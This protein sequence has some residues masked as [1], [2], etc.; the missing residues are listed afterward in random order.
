MDR[1]LSLLLFALVAVF[2]ANSV[3]SAQK[4]SPEA[5]GK[6]IY[7]EG[8][9][10][11]GQA[12]TAT[13]ASG[14]RVAGR[15]AACATCHRN[16][17]LGAAEGENIIRPLTVPGFFAGQDNK[18]RYARRPT[19]Q[20]QELHYTD[21]AF[22]HALSAGVATDG[23]VLN[24]L[25]PRYVLAPADV[26]AL[27]A[28][29][30]SVARQASPG[31]TGNDIHFATIIAPDA[32]PRVRDATLQV[33]HAMVDARNAGTRG[34]KH[35]L[36]AGIDHMHVT[37]RNWSLHVW[38]LSGGVETWAAQLDRLYRE[39]PVFAVVSGAGHRWQPVHDFCESNE[40]PCLF[41]NLD[42][43]GRAAPSGYNLYLTRG[44]LLEADVMA[45]HL[46]TLGWKGPVWQIRRD[47]YLAEAGARAFESAWQAPG[48]EPVQE[49]VLRGADRLQSALAQ[50]RAGGPAAV[51]L[52]LEGKDLEQQVP[53][54]LTADSPL[55]ASG[56]L[57]GD[58]W[59]KLA[60]PIAQQLLIAWPFTLPAPEGRRFDPVQSWLVTRGITSGDHRTQA[61]TY[62][63]VRI[64]SD[65]VAH[66]GNNYSRDYL[67]ERLEHS[68][69]K[70]LTTG[71]FPQLGLGPGQRFASKGAYLVQVQGQALTPQ[72][73]WIVP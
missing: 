9:L 68:A 42:V 16:S 19:L 54:G 39:Q 58:A 37:W 64:V 40:I 48:K 25:M 23:R 57:L 31:V 47:D 5:V 3:G 28:Y 67:I 2:G 18:R 56:T 41:P 53:F 22:E 7:R 62:F 69:D 20:L 13:L 11:S 60:A 36:Q 1:P 46:T 66:L 43:P 21:T 32:D 27:R 73:G 24:P 14:V 34:E 8:R 38:E 44:M 30:S 55:L 71:A 50:V 10:G 52:W 49:L 33:L 65:T 45:A 6:L 35:R 63:A 15:Q 51:V 59:P 29:L 12:L 72:S 26:S 4:L 17:G 61:N 70:A